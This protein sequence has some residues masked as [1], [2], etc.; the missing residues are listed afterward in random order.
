MKNF[1]ADYYDKAIESMKVLD[2]E[3][4]FML[5]TALQI[6]SMRMEGRR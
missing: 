1:N 5:L 6:K 3:K 2:D 4:W